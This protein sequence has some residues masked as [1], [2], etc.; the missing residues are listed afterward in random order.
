VGFVTFYGMK[1]ETKQYVKL[2]VTKYLHRFHPDFSAT[3]I[4]KIA[5]HHSIHPVISACNDVD[6]YNADICN[7]YHMLSLTNVKLEVIEK[8]IAPNLRE[9]K[10]F[11]RIIR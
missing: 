8:T 2:Q 7:Y 5:K 9:S 3:R 6:I 11:R 10:Q 4:E 1:N